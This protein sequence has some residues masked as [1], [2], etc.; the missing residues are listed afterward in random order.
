MLVFKPEFTETICRLFVQS[1]DAHLYQQL[2][3]SQSQA[4][5]K[6]VLNFKTFTNALIGDEYSFYDLMHTQEGFLTLQR[7]FIKAVL[8]LD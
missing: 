6:D 3:L 8:L 1:N 5:Q 7:Y 4:D 2:L